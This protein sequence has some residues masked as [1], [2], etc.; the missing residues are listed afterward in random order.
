MKKNLLILCFSLITVAL[1]SWTF[2]EYNSKYIK[3][4]VL[5]TCG[6]PTNLSYYFDGTDIVF[7]WTNTGNYYTY[8]GYYNYNGSFSGTTYG[9]TLYLPY[10]SGGRFGV[11]AHCNESYPETTSGTVTILFPEP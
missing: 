8:G 9:N 11:T 7:T 4:K 6:E 5:F 10:I 2:T 3:K 1:M